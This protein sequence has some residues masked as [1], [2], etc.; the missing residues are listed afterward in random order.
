[1]LVGAVLLLVST[2]G[3]S[4]GQ[5]AP[6]ISSLSPS[7]GPV[8]SVGS[9]VTIK[10]SG[11]G[12][13]QG[14][15]TVSFGGITV[16]PGSWT[17]TQ[18]VVPI[19]S[20]LPV[21]FADVSVTV[22]G[23]TSNASSFLVIPV[24]TSLSPVSG[25]I[26]TLV[27]ITGTSFGDQ[28]GTSTVTFNGV[29]ATPAAWSNTS[30]TLPVPNAATYGP[31]VVTVNGFQTNGATFSVLP[32]ILSLSPNAGQ[33]NSTV[34]INGTTF[35]PTQGFGGVTFNGVSA[36]IQSWSDTSVTAV[37]PPAATSGNVVLTTGRLLNSNAVTF[38]IAIPPAI[39][40]VSPASGIVG[41]QITISGSNFGATQGQVSLGG[42]P[43]SLSSWSDT[44]ILATIPSGAA[45]GN[46][47]VT[48]SNGLSSNASAFTISPFVSGVTP[49]NGL[50][51][52]QITIN[53]SGFG[54]AQGQVKIGI[55]PMTV[56]SWSDTAIVAA[57]PAGAMTGD[58]VVTTNAGLLSNGVGFA[59]SFPLL[60]VSISDTP[61]NVNLTSAQNL[62]WVHWG[63]LSS[64][65]PDRKAGAAPQIG[66][67]APTNG[68][69]RASSGVVAF[70]WSDGDHSSVVSE[71]TADVQTLTANSGFQITVPADTTAKTLNLYLEVSGGT[72][73]LQASL[74]DGS[75]PA[76]TDQSVTDLEF[77]SKIYSIDFRAASAGQALT[78]TFSA[79]PE[80]TVGLQAATLTAHLPVVSIS[81]PA[82]R[83]QFTAPATVPV[84]ISASQFDSFISDIKAT[85]SDGTVLE[86]PGTPLNLNWGPLPGGHYSVTATAT[87]TA[88]LIGA[89]APVE[90]DVIGQGGT[91]SIAE[92]VPA[93]SID[94]ES[95]GTAD[96]VLWGRSTAADPPGH[97]LARKNGVGP[98]IS[99]YKPIGNHLIS[100]TT[101]VHNLCFTSSQ[102]S[103][104]S[105]AEIMVHDQDNGFEINV[106]ADTTPRTL[107]LYISTIS[108]DA[109]VM[110]FLSDGSAPAA[111]EV[112]GYRPESQ[113]HHVL[114]DQ[115][116]R[117]FARPDAHGAGHFE[118]RPG[119]RSSRPDW[120]N[121]QRSCR[122]PI[123]SI[124]SDHFRYPHQCPD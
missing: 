68:S 89:S 93:A 73:I 102:Q 5:A 37:V 14:S 110:A 49:T 48:A 92:I 63:R 70:S 111:T 57:I 28:Q 7:V 16:T 21:G 27:T 42:Q 3:I 17:S 62:D 35:E 69:V 90:F 10:G 106:A 109:K 79:G 30:I 91:L 66:D 54:A 38:N 76:I 50:S 97:V 9:P 115:F 71:T 85:G 33:I 96:W 8:G 24:I 84:S 41:S 103:Y 43:L 120:S 52:A 75:A 34:T 114:S 74:S 80:G 124:P 82:A 26:G 6:S 23:L 46:L 72:G 32:N 39:G 104:C 113:Y 53:G 36:A 118:C 101:F 11:F 116:Q 4:L 67:Y 86:N 121:P 29:T 119:A 15:S 117:G 61:L 51:G 95:Q 44:S 25:P 56:S 40:S 18:I 88:G 47:V 99:E 58:V 22:G 100:A 65:T 77:G 83:Q 64:T 105:G 107:Q 112:R 55:H 2:C 12:A 81:S 98:L 60:Q 87:D 45:T 13:T 122:G 78:V 123:S 19:P 59:V 1:M 94:L 31:A 108:A 20:T